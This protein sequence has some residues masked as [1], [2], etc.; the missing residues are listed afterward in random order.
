VLSGVCVLTGSERCDGAGPEKSEWVELCWRISVGWR[1]AST[2][3]RYHMYTSYILCRSLYLIR[4]RLSVVDV[5]LFVHCTTHMRDWPS[6]LWTVLDVVRYAPRHNSVYRNFEWCRHKRWRY[7]AKHT[8]QGKQCSLVLGQFLQFISLGKTSVS[9]VVTVLFPF[10]VF[11]PSMTAYYVVKLLELCTFA[12]C[13]Y[14]VTTV[15]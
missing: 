1:V 11:C 2:C 4:L 13:F 10:S 9:T 6:M 7:S 12:A 14:S 5:K 8:H 3:I 15:Y